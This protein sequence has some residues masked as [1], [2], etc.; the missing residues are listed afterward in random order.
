[1]ALLAAFAG[2]GFG[3]RVRERIG[4]AAFQRALFLVFVGLGVANLLRGG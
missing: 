1:L 2:L 3:A 4:A